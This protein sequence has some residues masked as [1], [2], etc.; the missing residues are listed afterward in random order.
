MSNVGFEFQTIGGAGVDL[1]AAFESCGKRVV[2]FIRDRSAH[3]DFLTFR[4][5]VAERSSRNRYGG[6]FESGYAGKQADIGGIIT[7]IIDSSYAVVCPVVRQVGA[8]SEFSE[9]VSVRIR[10]DLYVL[11]H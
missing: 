10:L 6:A 9:T 3:R 5:A 1:Y 7:R 4:Y 8:E 2:S 11:R